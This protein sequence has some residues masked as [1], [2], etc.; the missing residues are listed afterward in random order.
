MMNRRKFFVVAAA[1]ATALAMPAFAQR[2]D[3]VY[4]L[5][6]LGSASAARWSRQLDALRTGLREHGYV[7]GKNVLIEYR[8]AED[9]NR[10]LPELAAELVR[11]KVDAIVTHGRA[12]TIAAKQATTV[13]PIV[14]ATSSDAVAS[15][16]VASLARPGGNVTG[17]TLISPEVNAKRVELLKEAFPRIARVAYFLNADNPDV[18]GAGQ[19]SVDDTARSAKVMLHHVSVRS[20]NTFEADFAALAKARIEGVVLS[21]DAL[22]VANANLCADLAKRH[23]LLSA[24]GRD[25]V[26]AGGLI[27]YGVEQAEMYRRAAYFVHR[28]LQGA[29]PAE[30]PVERASKFELIVNL[31][32]AKVLGVEVP[33]A[34]GLRADKVIE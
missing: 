19:R 13:I 8:W 29:K 3:R 7:E 18:S 12:G 27:G 20:A 14:M 16:L 24:G 22:F 30:L 10:R 9:N 1:T 32:T 6:F 21:D 23:R 11:L 33:H 15:R 2:A 25:F 31:K 5:G 26:E 4:R 17:L 28:V 34:M